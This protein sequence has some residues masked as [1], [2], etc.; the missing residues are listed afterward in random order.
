MTK[1][2]FFNYSL[3]EI[4][5]KCREWDENIW[6]LKN[7]KKTSLEIYNAY[8][9]NIKQENY[10]NKGKSL[11]LFKIKTNTLNLNE[12]KRFKGENTKCELFN[13]EREDLNHFLLHC[14]ALEEVRSRI[15]EWQR[16]RSENEND[17]IGKSLF[18]DEPEETVL[19][20][21]WNMRNNKIRDLNREN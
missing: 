14:S 4:K 17:I 16:P 18:K 9:E 8:K 12:R 20:E 10:Y 2:E 3:N 11:I 15:Y 13:Y 6:R 1:A 7:G 5:G 19:Y 21:M